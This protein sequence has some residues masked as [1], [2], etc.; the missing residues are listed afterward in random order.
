MAEEGEGE[1]PPS[2]VPAPNRA[3]EGD[4]APPEMGKRVAEDE[5]DNPEPRPTPVPSVV[6]DMV[7]FT[8]GKGSEKIVRR[9]RKRF[10]LD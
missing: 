3:G 8:A 7:E 1:I 5:E 4:A 9:D 10:Y 2:P 6:P